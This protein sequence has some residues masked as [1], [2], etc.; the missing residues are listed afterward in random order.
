M[1]MLLLGETIAISPDEI[2]FLTAR[3]SGP[4]GQNVNKRETKVTAR[5]NVASSRSLDEE[6][7]TRLQGKLGQ[8]ISN[9]GWLAVVCQEHRTQGANKQAALERLLAHLEEA[10]EVAAERRPT[11]IPQSLLRRRVASQKRHKAKKS[12]RRPIDVE[13]E[14]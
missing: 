6:T 7:K 1:S 9:E 12:S 8:H 11:K 14:A 10:L 3:S 4:G 13:A 2:E 5:F